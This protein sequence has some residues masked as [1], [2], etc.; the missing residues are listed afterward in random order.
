ML[1]VVAKFLKVLNSETEPGQI[2]LA[3]CLSMIAGL[4]PIA[5]PHN[6]L[7]FLLAF[8]LRVNLSA[9]ILGFGLFSGIAYGLDPL[10]HRIGL[11]VLTTGPLEGLWTVL[12]NI[13]V[14]RIERFNNTVVM[15][16]LVFS[17]VFFVP[18]L[19][20]S[21]TAVR[22]YRE[23]VLDW[24]EKTRAMKVVRASR[25]YQI[26]RSVSGWGGGI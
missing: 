17:L 19:L 8:L 2:S 23:H 21:N 4:T 14:W 25:F 12:Y 11:A 9:F 22:R 24:I 15:G 6:I 20:L 3:F 16:S 18:L 5:S 26:Y 7:V 10:F 13:T 1:R